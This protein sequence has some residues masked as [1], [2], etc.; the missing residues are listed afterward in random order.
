MTEWSGLNP[1]AI[2]SLRTSSSSNPNYIIGAECFIDGVSFCRSSRKHLRSLVEAFEIASV[3]DVCSVRQAR[4]CMINEKT[5]TYLKEEQESSTGRAINKIKIH[6]YLKYT[7]FKVSEE[8]LPR[9][10]IQLL[11]EARHD[12]DGGG[13]GGGGG[14]PYQN[15][16]ER[17]SR[18]RHQQSPLARVQNTQT[19]D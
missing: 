13:G 6:Y 19:L 11:R 17:R 15:L 10:V 7:P 16:H 5:D 8:L 9:R 18:I 3:F 2:L 1:R 4:R 12:N 14:P